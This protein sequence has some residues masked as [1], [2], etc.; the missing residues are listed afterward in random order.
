MVIAQ[1]APK[2][3]ENAEMRV[4]SFGPYVLQIRKD[5]QPTAK[6]AW[7]IYQPRMKRVS[8]FHQDKMDFP[9]KIM[10]LGRGQ[11]HARPV[12]FSRRY[13]PGLESKGS[14][15]FIRKSSAV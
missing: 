11:D 13:W 7:H 3:I 15:E 12:N 4:A 1:N 8:I 5:S 6:L 2:V 14:E 10:C 9:A